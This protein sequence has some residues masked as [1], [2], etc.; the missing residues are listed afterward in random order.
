MKIMDNWKESICV[1]CGQEQCAEMAPNGRILCCF[2]FGENLKD[3]KSNPFVAHW[4][5]DSRNS[6]RM[7][8]VKYERRRHESSYVF[9]Q[10]LGGI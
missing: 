10:T 9:H 6:N 5:I 8:H 4:K 3:R 7:W 1:D 2:C